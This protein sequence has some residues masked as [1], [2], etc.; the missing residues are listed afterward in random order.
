MPSSLHFTLSTFKLM[1]KKLIFYQTKV[2]DG[3][4]SF[5]DSEGCD[6]DRLVNDVIFVLDQVSSR[7]G[8]NVEKSRSL[9]NR[10]GLDVFWMVEY[11]EL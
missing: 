11:D 7:H 5:S 4:D 1:Q 9:L 6:S 2:S 3:Q 10:Q 8:Y